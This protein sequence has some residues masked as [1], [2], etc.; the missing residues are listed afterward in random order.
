[1]FTDFRSEKGI[2]DMFHDLF[3]NAVPIVG[4]S[5]FTIFSFFGKLDRQFDLSV[6]HD[7][8]DAIDKSD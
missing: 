4:H 2:K 1:V 3:R 7:S 8:F 6:V 5:D